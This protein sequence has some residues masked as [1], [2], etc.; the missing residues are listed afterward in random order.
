MVCKWDL[1]DLFHVL[2]LLLLGNAV[3]GKSRDENNP[4]APIKARSDHHLGQN[5]PPC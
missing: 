4:A 3:S 2:V 5:T 1:L